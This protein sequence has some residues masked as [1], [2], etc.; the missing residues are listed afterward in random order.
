MILICPAADGFILECARSAGLIMEDYELSGDLK[1][2][3]G[4]T[5]TVMSN[6][7][8]RFKKLFKV[9]S[10]DGEMKMLKELLDYLRNNRFESQDA[11]IIAIFRN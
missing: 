8:S 11:D 3:T 7:D 1:K 2:L 9:L 6:K 5:K 10:T 4:M